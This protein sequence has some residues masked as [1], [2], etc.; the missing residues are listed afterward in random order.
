MPAPDTR[1][2]AQRPEASDQE[3]ALVKDFKR[4]IEAVETLRSAKWVGSAEAG[5]VAAERYVSRKNPPSTGCGW[6]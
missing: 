2:D 4:R 1:T 3:K 5:S 6:S